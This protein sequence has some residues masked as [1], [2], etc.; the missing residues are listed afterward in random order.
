M[1]WNVA[2]RRPAGP[3]TRAP[4]ETDR[5]RDNPPVPSE[6]RMNFLGFAQYA[7]DLAE[8][9]A[10]AADTGRVDPGDLGRS[11]R[12]LLESTTGAPSDEP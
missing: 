8:R 11:A 7:L 6:P 3:A 9:L 12:R 5:G 4:A 10:A 2:R 1:A